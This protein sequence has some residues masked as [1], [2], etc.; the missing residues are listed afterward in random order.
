[1]TVR[2]DL[3]M[4]AR[5]CVR[6]SRESRRAES[7]SQH[8]KAYI[9]C[10][11]L[12]AHILPSQHKIR[13]TYHAFISERE[14]EP[15][16]HPGE[17]TKFFDRTLSHIHI[18][19]ICVFHISKRFMNNQRAR[20][21]PPRVIRDHCTHARTQKKRARAFAPRISNRCGAP[22]LQARSRTNARMVRKMIFDGLTNVL[23]TY[24]SS[25]NTHHI[26]LTCEC[27]A[28]L[29]RARRE[30]TRPRAFANNDE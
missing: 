5:V 24:E 4:L 29:T 22:L 9:K 7:V 3:A 14:N 30:L 27:L 1:M 21:W 16:R 6:T 25:T 20:V 18:P 17:Q 28:F 23:C 12:Q 11:H 26:S 19:T 8:W 15:L 2:R 13:R 10:A